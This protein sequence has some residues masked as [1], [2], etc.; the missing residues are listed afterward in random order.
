MRKLLQLES[1]NDRSIIIS[2]NKI[3]LKIESMSIALTD[4]FQ[5]HK[6][7]KETG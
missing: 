5:Y 4:W 2:S 6:N 3:H 7:K 1:C